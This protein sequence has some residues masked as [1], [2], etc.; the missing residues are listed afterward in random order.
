MPSPKVLFLGANGRDTTRLRL[1]AEVRDIRQE[2]EAADA[3]HAFQVMVELAVRPTDLQRLLLLHEPDVIHFS[4]HGLDP[5]SGNTVQNTASGSA[6]SR[7]FQTDEQTSSSTS[8]EIDGG[9]LLED[10]AGAAIAVRPE[11]LTTLLAL[12]DH[13]V[14]LQ[15]V[16]LNA[17]FTAAQARAIAEYVDCV[18]GTARAIDDDAAIA[19]ATAFY[20]AIARG[21]SVGK[22][23]DLGRNEIGLRGLP[24]QDVPQLFHRADINPN[25]VFL[26]GVPRMKPGYSERPP[27]P[28]PRKLEPHWVHIL[29]PAEFFQG[30]ERLR[31][32]L[33]TWLAKDG[34]ATRIVAICAIGGTGKTA[35]V[36]RVV[37][38]WLE[39]VGKT[40]RKPPGG[41][42]I[43]SFYENNHVDE[44]LAEACAYFVGEPG[45]SSGRSARLLAALKDGRS[46]LL[47]FDGLET[48]QAEEGGHRAK[49]E[50]IDPAFRLLVRQIAAKQ[51]GQTRLLATS[52]FLLCDVT[53]WEGE[54]VRTIHLEDLEPSAARDMLRMWGV[55]GH[56]KV[57]D[58]LAESVG[59][60]ALSVRVMGAYL[61][62][63][64]EGD[65]EEGLELDLDVMAK[66]AGDADQKAFKLDKMLCHLSEKMTAAEREL[67]THISFFHRGIGVEMLETLVNA[68]VSGA[69]ALA[70]T[71]QRQ[72]L[73]LVR[74]LIA[75]GLAFSH[76][77][78]DQR[79]FT[80]HP[81]VRDHF[82]KLNGA[83]ATNVHELLRRRLAPS[84]EH[85][86]GKTT[87]D[88]DTLDRFEALIEHTRL[89]GETEEAFELYWH[90]MG[91]YKHLGPLLGEYRRARRIVEG[92][93]PDGTPAHCAL[94]LPVPRR[95]LL[96]NDWATLARNVG[97][98]DIANACMEVAIDLVRRE[99]DQTSLSVALHNVARLDFLRG[100]LTTMVRHA[101]E[102][103]AMGKV[104]KDSIE[105]SDS[106]GLVA[107]GAFLTGRIAVA[108]HNFAEATRV[109]GEPLRAAIGLWEAKFYHCLGHRDK[110]LEMSLQ[111][112]AYCE[113]KR[114][115]GITALLYAFIGHLILPDSLAEARRY[116]A[117]AGRLSAATDHVEGVIHEKDLAA[118]I[119]LHEDHPDLAHAEASEGF[120]LAEEHKYGVDAI[121]LLLTL[122]RA[123]VARQ[124]PT[125]AFRHAKLA[126]ERSTQPE[127]GYVW[128]KADALHLMGLA[129]RD[130]G[131]RDHARARFQQAAEFR[132]G[133][134][135]PGANESREK[136]A[137][138]DAFEQP[139]DSFDV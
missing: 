104:A 115:K 37:R 119:H 121:D 95:T 120:Q 6:T 75:R 18:V 118:A 34:D 138:C 39:P 73:L 35:L 112:L 116:L 125:E 38:D 48:V 33:G 134:E 8:K 28:E 29:E 32:E 81:F 21:K 107:F 88:K 13:D 130:S 7:E 93:S 52:R 74:R 47:V 97:D 59:W 84:L 69:A 62:H 123:A 108:R 51:V 68:G 15:C 139:V 42:F 10:D 110:A 57:L 24:G 70:G 106:Q 41:V 26:E 30:R 87:G 100:R 79:V 96:L 103:L 85:Q 53:S 1:N 109:A 31:E 50:I 3:A 14:P 78:G 2:L 36:E 129:H 44:F 113:Q 94:D 40:F 19:F 55:R 89:S 122:A 9:L 16:V 82:K 58:A 128:G 25:N 56:D 132:A 23:F 111:N 64:A 20:R 83:G 65:A 66:E 124:A 71:N 131:E 105:T 102:A 43:W 12:V 98:L 76:G 137:D 99:M 127:C 92:F 90:G 11:V 117:L 86:P 22:A 72:L 60:H 77:D 61:K 54:G 136:A 114:Y 17:C 27:A 46:H 63:Y 67:M 5:E 126:L 133:I 4:G 101:D 135:H 45:E 49:G 91:G 80:A